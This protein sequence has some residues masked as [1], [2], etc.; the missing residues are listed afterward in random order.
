VRHSFQWQDDAGKSH[1]GSRVLFMAPWRGKAIIG[2]RHLPLENPEDRQVTEAKIL[3]FLKIINEAYPEI[4]IERKDVIHWHWGILP[5]EGKNRFS[6]DADLK[7]HSQIID[8][9]S[10]GIA[11]LLTVIGVKFTTARAI[12]EDAVQQAASKLNYSLPK[13]DSTRTPLPGG[14]EFHIYMHQEQIQNELPLIPDATA[15]RLAHLYGNNSARIIRYKEH[16]NLLSGSILQAE[17]IYAIRDEMA[18]HLTDVILRRTDIGSAGKPADELV[19]AVAAI[20]AKELK[21]DEA[22]KRQEIS[23]LSDFYCVND[24]ISR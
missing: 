2:T 24:S 12:A 10:A 6:G 22:R 18:L 20:M 17:I 3:E 13:I 4:E 5:M 9:A 19:D 8:H 15:E 11:N 23:D 16:L 21:W 7:R 1:W 14:R